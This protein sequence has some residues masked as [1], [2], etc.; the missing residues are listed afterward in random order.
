MVFLKQTFDYVIGHLEA[1]LQST[2]SQLRLVHKASKSSS[3]S[4]VRRSSSLKLAA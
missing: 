2:G 3:F 1:F 4:A